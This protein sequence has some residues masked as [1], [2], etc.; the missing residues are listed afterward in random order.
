MDR[1]TIDNAVE[2]E[3]IDYS[4]AFQAK[5]FGGCNNTPWIISRPENAGP[6][7]LRCWLEQLN[8]ITQ[9][10]CLVTKR[11]KE[12]VLTEQHY[13]HGVMPD[14][15]RTLFNRRIRSE[16]QARHAKLRRDQGFA[17]PEASASPYASPSNSS[18]FLRK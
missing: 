13:A 1:V 3:L 15:L 11:E 7:D 12:A 17:S 6:D 14:N 5:W 9:R 10:M 18:S 8:H 2:L 4:N 16:I